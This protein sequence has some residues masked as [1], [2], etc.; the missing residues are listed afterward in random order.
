MQQ[1]CMNRYGEPKKRYRN[2]AAAKFVADYH[3]T[4]KGRELHAYTCP[5]CGQYHVAGDDL[6]PSNRRAARRKGKREVQ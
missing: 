5:D 6:L 1:P 2:V 4:V 3:R